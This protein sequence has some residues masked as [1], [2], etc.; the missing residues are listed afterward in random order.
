M[1]E[2]IEKR[3]RAQANERGRKKKRKRRGEQRQRKRREGRKKNKNIL[4]SQIKDEITESRGKPNN[5]ILIFSS[6]V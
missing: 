4:G 2:D 6:R 1:R 3:P 5:K